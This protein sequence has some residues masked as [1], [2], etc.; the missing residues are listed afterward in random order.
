[1]LGAS[2]GRFQEVELAPAC[3]LEGNAA[4]L[5]LPIVEGWSVARFD[6]SY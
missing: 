1:V 6:E 2:G 4:E 5:R 3:H